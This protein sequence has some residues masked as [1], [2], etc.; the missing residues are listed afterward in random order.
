MEDY[1]FTTQNRNYEFRLSLR[2]SSLSV[3]SIPLVDAALEIDRMGG[4]LRDF[5]SFIRY[6]LLELE[7]EQD[8]R[9]PF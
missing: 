4:D 7:K 1:S 2:F 3:E 9:V 8:D 6:R 5:L